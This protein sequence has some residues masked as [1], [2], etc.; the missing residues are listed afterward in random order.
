MIAKMIES[1][2]RKSCYKMPTNFIQKETEEESD[3]PVRGG[4]GFYER[5]FAVDE[6]DKWYA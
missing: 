4:D 6:I 5:G 1:N 3:E 2:R